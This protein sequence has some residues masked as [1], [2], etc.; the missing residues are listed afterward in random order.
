ML[1]GQGKR[2]TPGGAF[3]ELLKSF[4]NEEQMRAINKFRKDKQRASARNKATREVE[5]SV[6]LRLQGHAAGQRKVS[7]STPSSRRG[8]HGNR[9]G[10][11][12]KR[13]RSPGTGGRGH[14]DA[15][16]GRKLQQRQP[17]APNRQRGEQSNR[18]H[19][20]QQTLRT[21]TAPRQQDTLMI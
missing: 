17:R 8:G 5:N 19:S 21:Q 4:A 16:S 18:R 9:G 10:I 13:D 11:K 7:S 3:F 14:V 15:R 2:R 1:S 6:G 20:V 12:K